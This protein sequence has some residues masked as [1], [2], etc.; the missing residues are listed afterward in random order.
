MAADIYFKIVKDT[1]KTG[2]VVAV[3]TKERE[4]VG[5]L[6]TSAMQC[7]LTDCRLRVG[8]KGPKSGLNGFEIIFSSC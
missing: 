3:Q 7:A 2:C 4:K 5:W 8:L 1:T 6:E